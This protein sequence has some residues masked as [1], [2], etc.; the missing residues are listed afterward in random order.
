MFSENDKQ[1]TCACGGGS[2]SG[3]LSLRPFKESDALKMAEWIRDRDTYYMLGGPHLAPYPV[4]AEDIIGKY[5]RENGG[6]AEADNFYPM[7]A[8]ENG[9]PVGQLIV[10][11]TGG[12]RRKLRFGWVVVDGRKRGR[13]YGREM[14]GLGL[15]F[16]FE[17]MGASLVTI[18]VFEENMRAYNCYVSAGFRANPDAQVKTETVDGKEQKII[19]LVITREEYYRRKT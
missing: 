12:D 19:E 14:L 5:F 8:T 2:G 18:G 10:R 15:V 6:C 9:E 13:G 11:Y 3:F 7:T 17:V 4:S 16:A 1:D